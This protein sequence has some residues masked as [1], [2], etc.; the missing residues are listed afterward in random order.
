MA[1]KRCT[2]ERGN[3]LRNLAKDID[4]AVKARGPES[5]NLLL[6]LASD[7]DTAAKASVIENDTLLQRL[8]NSINA[9][10]GANSSKRDNLLKNLANNIQAAIE[11]GNPTSRDSPTN[12]E[13]MKSLDERYCDV[14]GEIM[15]LRLAGTFSLHHAFSCLLTSSNPQVTWMVSMFS[16][17][18]VGPGPL[19]QLELRDPAK[20]F[21]IVDLAE[22]ELLMEQKHDVLARFLDVLKP[23]VKVYAIPPTSLHIFA[24]KNGRFI[25]FNRRGNLFLNLQYFEA[26]RTFCVSALLEY[27]ISIGAC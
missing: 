26:W 5:D 24:D 11:L 12:Q 19:I 7:I 6:K 8:L 18:Q 16:R 4:K 21:L 25:S 22:P 3:L 17:R 27:S 13:E 14:T 2:P 9:A 20:N 10:I 1:I 23:L 15:D